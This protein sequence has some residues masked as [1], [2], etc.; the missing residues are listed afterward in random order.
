MWKFFARRRL[1]CFFLVFV[2]V[3]LPCPLKFR[4]KLRYIYKEI[5]QEGQN[6]CNFPYSFC[7][8]LNSEI[9]K[10]KS[11]Y[12]LKWSKNWKYLYFPTARFYAMASFAITG[13]HC[14]FENFAIS[15]KQW[16]GGR[17]RWTQ[18]YCRFMAVSL[19]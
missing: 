12:L 6:I 16:N 18:Y 9:A 19:C 17:R 7:S 1:E 4:I 3:I 5:W 11:F 13:V 2:I 8:C 14:I 15:I 10:V